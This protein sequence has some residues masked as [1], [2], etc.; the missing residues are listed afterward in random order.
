MIDN[1]YI[2]NFANNKVSAVFHSGII[3][4]FAKITEFEFVLGGAHIWRPFKQ[5][6]HLSLS[7]AI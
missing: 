6:K 2:N 7:F 5:K 4:C 1:W 3:K